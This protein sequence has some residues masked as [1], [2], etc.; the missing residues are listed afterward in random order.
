LHVW[1][2][3]GLSTSTD[4]GASWSLITPPGSV[5]DTNSSYWSF[6]MDF[7]HPGTMFVSGGYGLLGVWKST[8]GGL[9]WVDTT[10]GQPMAHP[11]DRQVAGIAMDPSDPLHVLADSHSS[12]VGGLCG[13]DYDC[14]LETVDGGQSWRAVRTPF[15]FVENSGMLFV[16]RTTWIKC[17]DY[18][19]WRT[20]DSGENWT[21]VSN[22]LGCNQEANVASFEPQ[23]DGYRYATSWTSGLVRTRDDGLI[24]EQVHGG[25][26]GTLAPAGDRL[27]VSDQWSNSYWSVSLEESNRMEP[28]PSVPDAGEQGAPFLAWDGEH[29][30]LYASLWPKGLWRIVIP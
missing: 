26:M 3:H 22:T 13:A 30:V 25:R 7:L 28:L 27:F 2:E 16:D 6:R 20:A 18:E 12:D 8:N 15:G 10:V 5:I 23:A 24:F 29:R 1:N 19:I 9:D 14:I 17:K 21:R 11:G 4:C